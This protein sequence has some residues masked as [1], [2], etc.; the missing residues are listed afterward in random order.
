[1]RFSRTEIWHIARAW[2]AI[3]LAFAILNN[4]GLSLNAVFL[5]ILGISAITVGTG[6]IGHELSHKYFAQKYGLMSEFRAF[7]QYLVLAIVMS[8]F[9][10]LFAAPGAVFISGRADRIRYGRI[11][12][13]GPAANIVMAML[14]AAIAF[15]PLPIIHII[16]VS[17]LSIN[18]W[19][20][21][22]NLIPFG[23]L[24]GSKVLAWNKVAYGLLIISAAVMM[25]LS[26]VI[27][28]TKTF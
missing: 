22:F 9:G 15:V 18:A 20:A 27:P 6:F 2:A 8:F 25:L 21:L 11:S 1:M 5:A 7:D 3:T 26:Y 13:A 17:G 10:F 16:G 23:S 4:G 28:A 14:F 19:L 24:D 12:A